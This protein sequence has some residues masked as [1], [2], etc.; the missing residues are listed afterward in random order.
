M[1]A[2]L[3]PF[4]LCGVFLLRSSK[5]LCLRGCI[6]WPHRRKAIKGQAGQAPEE[7]TDTTGGLGAEGAGQDVQEAAPP[8]D[9][10]L[11]G[12][13]ADAGFKAHIRSGAGSLQDVDMPAF[14]EAAMR[15]REAILTMGTAVKLVV[16]DFQKNYDYVESV[17]EEDSSGRRRTLLAFLQTELDLGVHSVGQGS[18]CKLCNPSG[19]LMLQWLL[20]GLEFM[21]TMLKLMF[22]GDKYAANSAYAKTLQQYHGWVTSLGIRAALSGMPDRKGVCSI[23]AL[24]PAM[25]QNPARLSAAITRD[26]QRAVDAMLPMVQWMI[27]AFKEKGLWESSQV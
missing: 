21:F 20:R 12:V 7:M 1:T 15:Y 14:L 22:D 3:W 8:E 25:E 4:L 2:D 18:S 11:I 23:S 26:I 13:V 6:N 27:S 10:T 16:G 5:R 9:Q 17:L 24:C 19:A